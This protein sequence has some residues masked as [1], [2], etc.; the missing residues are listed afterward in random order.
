MKLAIILVFRRLRISSNSSYIKVL[1]SFYSLSPPSLLAFSSASSSILCYY[2][3]P[4]FLPLLSSPIS[5]CSHSPLLTEQKSLL[6]SYYTVQYSS[7]ISHKTYKGCHM[8]LHTDT[9]RE[10]GNKVTHHA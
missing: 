2:F 6:F 3:I 8:P 7:S 9:E 10:I 1:V 5:H 4:P